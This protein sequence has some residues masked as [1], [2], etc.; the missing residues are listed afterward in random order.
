MQV[1]TVRS[2]RAHPLLWQFL[3]LSMGTLLSF[4]LLGIRIQTTGTYYFL[5]LVW[6]LFL[7]W[8]PYGISTLVSL[9]RPQRSW[10]Q[11]S[12]FCLWLLFLPNAPCILTDLFH[13]RPRPGVPIWMDLTL[14][15]SFAITSLWLG[16]ASLQH[17]QKALFDH[18]GK[19]LSW[20]TALLILMLCSFGVYLGRF[21]RWNSWDILTQP[22]GLLQ[23]IWSL[24]LG[25][26]D[27]MWG[28][29]LAFG[30]LLCICYLAFGLRQP[31]SV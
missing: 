23:D 24:V 7:A 31:A 13:L 17:M 1:S 8:I 21:L 20:A 25:F 29:T 2:W 27:G 28:F 9:K 5:F 4:G 12:A 18:W 22:Q 11:L 16:M 3:G 6:N 30:G 14:I 19:W 15:L 26:D 10:M